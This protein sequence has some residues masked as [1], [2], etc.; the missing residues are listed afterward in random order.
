VGRRVVQVD[1]NIGDRAALPARDG[2]LDLP[3]SDLS[4]GP[5]KIEVVALEEILANKLYMLD[6]R[7]EPR[8]LFDLWFGICVKDVPLEQISEAFRAKYGAKPHV[9]R[10]ERARKLEKNLGRSSWPPSG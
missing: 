1:V 3:Y 10:V 7:E 2:N 5:W 4:D 8:D 6:D 9:W